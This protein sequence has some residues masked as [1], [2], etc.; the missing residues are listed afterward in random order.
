MVN[1]IEETSFAQWTPFIWHSVGH[2]EFFSIVTMTE[3]LQNFKYAYY[4]FPTV[5]N[6]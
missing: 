5:Y 6:I 1:N 3:Y 4:F 2:W